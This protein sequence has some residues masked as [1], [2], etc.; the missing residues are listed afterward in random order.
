MHGEAVRSAMPGLK[1]QGA[2]RSPPPSL[3]EPR[4]DIEIMNKD[5]RALAP[6]TPGLQTPVPMEFTVETRQGAIVAGPPASPQTPRSALNP[7]SM[8]LVQPGAQVLL[9]GR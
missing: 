2:R 4:I 1:A 3:I 6:S 5:L 8:R 9:Q 7:R